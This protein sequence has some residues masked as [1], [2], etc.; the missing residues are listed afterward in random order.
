MLNTVFLWYLVQIN[1]HNYS[2]LSA[3][4]EHLHLTQPALSSAIKSL[5]E[6]LHIKLLNR[7]YKGITLTEEGKQVVKKAE[8]IFEL[9]DEVEYMF[10]P[11]EKE[12]EKSFF[13]DDYIIYSIPAYSPLL[14][15]ALSVNYSNQQSFNELQIFNSTVELDI[16]KTISDSSNTIIMMILP[17]QYILPPN[18]SM[19]I[20]KKSKAYLM[21]T[22]DFPYIKPEQKSISLKNIIDIPLVISKMTFDFQSTLL[23]LLKQY[24]KPQIKIIAPD[25]NTVSSAIN[26]GLVAGFTN[27]FS[28]SPASKHLRY[29]L[30]RNS[31]QFNLC[32]LYG[33]NTHPSIILQ[34]SEL[35]KSH[36]V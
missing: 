6:Q 19:T 11:P 32:L 33:K 30:I 25:S 27:K 36:L 17:E 26:N 29:V 20:L 31:P 34:L 10:L 22:D 3:A 5:E 16:A 21:C 12:E 8:K 7:S 24:G 15:S 2:S 4:A 14:M 18:V 1:K 13:L 9:L 23:T 28:V 35:L